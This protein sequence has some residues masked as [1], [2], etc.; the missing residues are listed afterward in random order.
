MSTRAGGERRK[1]PGPN[2]D[3][4]TRILPTRTGAVRSTPHRGNSGAQ[5]CEDRFGRPRLEWTCHPSPVPRALV[6]SRLETAE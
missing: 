5:R 3:L 4:R 6:G 2:S 1:T